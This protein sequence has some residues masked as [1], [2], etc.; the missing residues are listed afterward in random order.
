LHR[1]EDASFHRYGIAAR[2]RLVGDLDGLVHECMRLRYAR[3]RV[4]LRKLGSFCTH[5]RTALVLTPAARHA[6]VSVS[7]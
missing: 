6:C 4:T 2:D 3:R 1:S 5:A 7:P